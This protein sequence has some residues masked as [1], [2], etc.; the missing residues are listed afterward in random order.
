MNTALENF[1]SFEWF[2]T[3]GFRNTILAFEILVFTSPIICLF[4]YLFFP[5]AL[6]VYW[7][8]F[9]GFVS[10]SLVMSIVSAFEE[11]EFFAI[12]IVALVCF[13]AAL[14]AAFR[15]SDVQA[16]RRAHG[17]VQAVLR[18]MKHDHA[19]EITLVQGSEYN[20]LNSHGKRYVW[21]I[22]RED[23]N[24]IVEKLNFV[25]EARDKYSYHGPTANKDD[26]CLVKDGYDICRVGNKL[27][28]R[29]IGATKTEISQWEKSING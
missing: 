10:C 28:F 24:G 12:G 11:K 19:L 3:K 26:N 6:S 13:G 7:L 14:C 23:I 9:G 1:R 17:R 21:A 29:K 5:P 25:D 15:Y 4:A 22:G 27:R 18:T 8:I 16:D 20:L 2:H